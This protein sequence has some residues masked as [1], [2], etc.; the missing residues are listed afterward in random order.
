E[1]A[2]IGRDC[3]IYSNVTVREHCV[4]GDRV[5]LHPGAVVGSDGFGYEFVEGR[6]QKI[7]QVGIVELGNDV[8]VG[9]N[10]TI[11]RARFGRTRIGEGTKID[12]LVQIGHNVE[13]GKH[14]IV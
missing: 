5:T 3:R 8:E 4:L 7:E 10:T 9:A 2:S 11:D 6:H 12:N 14:S 13:I 1:G